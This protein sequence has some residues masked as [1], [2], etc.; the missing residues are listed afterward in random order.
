MTSSRKTQA[1]HDHMTQ[2]YKAD[3]DAAE[4]IFSTVDRNG[5]GTISREEFGKMYD[6]VKHRVQTDNLALEKSQRRS[7]ILCMASSVLVVVIGILLAGNAGL[8]YSLLEI[9]KESHA[10]AVDPAKGTRAGSV[11]TDVKGQAMSIAA[12]SYEV[13]AS[14]LCS[15]PEHVVSNLRVCYVTE[16]APYDIGKSLTLRRTLVADEVMQHTFEKNVSMVT[17]NDVKK[18]LSLVALRTPAGDSVAIMRDV[19][20]NRTAIQLGDVTSMS[21]TLQYLQDAGVLES[22]VDS[23]AGRRLGWNTQSFTFGAISSVF[24][25]IAFATGPMGLVCGLGLL[26]VSQFLEE[27]RRLS[28]YNGRAL[29]S[30]ADIFAISSKY[31]IDL[32]TSIRCVGDYHVEAKLSK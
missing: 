1:L 17:L 14:D 24:C 21:V 12:S 13:N 22:L 5:D 9:T 25:Y 7:R 8:V 3:S 27:R 18:E 29:M 11:L 10:R 20:R 28:D 16:T 15:A 6:V 19:Q 23:G 32:I 4:E 26:V 30:D 2:M 31:G